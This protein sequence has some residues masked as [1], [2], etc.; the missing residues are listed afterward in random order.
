MTKVPEHLVSFASELADAAGFIILNYWRVSGLEIAEK[1][2]A[3]R[4]IATSP[5][6]VADRASERA[7]RDLIAERYPN[8]GVYGEEFGEERVDA[9][10][11]WVLDPI[12]G[13]KSFIT[14][15]PLFGTLIALLHRGRPVLGCIDQCVLGERWIGANGITLLNG[16]PVA[17]NSD[18]C[19]GKTKLASTIMY[20][21]TPHMFKPGFEQARFQELRGKV[22]RCL[23]GCDCYAYAIVASGFGAGLVVE[24]GQ[25]IAC[26]LSPLSVTDT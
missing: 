5:V 26:L 21:T 3:H 11:V 16:E 1:D 13:T 23:Y 20:A 6:T 8:H 2:E 12:D 15:K 25:S 7:M 10:Y 4:A 24:A 17:R 22:R 14:G 19:G 9:E 18:D